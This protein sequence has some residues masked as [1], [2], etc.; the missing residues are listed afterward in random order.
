MDLEVLLE[1]E[2]DVARAEEARHARQ[3][4]AL[5]RV[6]VALGAMALVGATVALYGYS[7]R[8]SLR[9]A[10]EL[11]AVRK[12]GAESFDKLETCE[13]AHNI[14]RRETLACGEDRK[15]DADEHTRALGVVRDEGAR[16]QSQLNER[17]TAANTKLQTCEEDTERLTGERDEIKQRHDEAQAKWDEDRTRLEQERE[18]ADNSRKTCEAN[19][20]KLTQSQQTCQR[21]L[22]SCESERVYSGKPV[23][24][25]KPPPPGPAPPLPEE[26]PYD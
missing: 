22:A 26:N 16:E 3:K 20:E 19:T 15:R 11:E 5:Q 14:S 25:P 12:E 10:N 4:V 24:G 2:R 8:E 21:E 6:R 7:K 18:T 23:A 13:A 17:L 9:L 1:Q